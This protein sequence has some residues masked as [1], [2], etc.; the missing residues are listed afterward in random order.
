MTEFAIKRIMPHDELAEQSVIGSMLMDKDEENNIYLFIHSGSRHFGM[1]VAYYYLRTG[2]K[3]MQMKKQGY[4]SY[5]MT[6]LTGEL[7]EDYLH[8]QLC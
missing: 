2:Q 4:A 6:C 3:E 8:S 5:E 1:E 7:M